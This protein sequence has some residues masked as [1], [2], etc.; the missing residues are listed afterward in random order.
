M[1]V[2]KY[3]GELVTFDETALRRSLSRSGANDQEVNMVYESIKGSVYDGIPTKELYEMAFNALRGKKNS[4]AARYSLKR[5]IREL[6]PEGFYFEKWIARLFQED[7]Y[8]AVTGQT[9]QG[10]A[11][12]HEIDVVA[13]KGNEMLAIECKFRNDADA[14]ISVTTPM[15][16]KSRKEDITGISYHFFNQNHEFTDGWLVTNAYLTSDSIAFGNYYKV[17]LLSWDYPRG[18]SL[19]K[20]VDSNAEYPVTCLTNISEQDKAMLL[21]FQCIL[22]KDLVKSPQILDKIQVAK[23]KQK[24]ILME[25]NELINSPLEHE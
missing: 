1:R 11:V 19:K 5:A 20:R 25:A 22:V 24:L 23:D 13:L 15:Y 2:K 21:K 7:G 12:S 18:S 10:H 8:E 17:N 9:V 6:G 3:S 4:Y 16:F 14:K